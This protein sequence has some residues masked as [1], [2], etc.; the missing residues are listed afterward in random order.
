MRESNASGN[1]A[2]IS[3]RTETWSHRRSLPTSV[4][5]KKILKRRR[6]RGKPGALAVSVTIHPDKP[7]ALAVS[8][9]IRPDKP[10]AFQDGGAGAAV[11]VA[12]NVMIRP[13]EPEAFGP[14]RDG[15]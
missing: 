7:G 9:T 11:G 2:R 6:G 12:A 13:D 15:T 10:G 4:A 8:V 3:A 5:G 14:S 1:L